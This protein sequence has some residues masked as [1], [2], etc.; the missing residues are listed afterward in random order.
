[1]SNRSRNHISHALLSIVFS[2][3][4]ACT[5]TT[6]TPPT[7]PVNLDPLTATAQNIAERQA[8]I[9]ATS[10]AIELTV[11]AGQFTSTPLPTNASPSET[12]VPSSPTPTLAATQPATALPSATVQPSATTAVTLTSTAQPTVTGTVQAGG[13]PVINTFTADKLM[14]NPGEPLTFT[15]TT[16]NA[17]TVTI[18]H[19]LS[20][21]MFG[22]MGRGDLP[23]NGSAS[24]LTDSN[25]VNTNKFILI[26][27]NNAGVTVS[28]SLDV[29][30]ACKHPWF[31][32]PAPAYCS[33]D[34]SYT[35]SMIEQVFQGGRMVWIA[36]PQGYNS[37]SILY[38]DGTIYTGEDT[39]KN[40]EP[41]S[42]P[43]LVPPAGLYQPVRGFGKVW[44]ELQG[45]RDK[46][47]WALGVETPYNGLFQYEGGTMDAKGWNTYY[48]LEDGHVVHVTGHYGDVAWEYVTP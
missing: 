5:T 48:A 35:R 44:R 24:I 10:T 1:M 47:G 26:V 38:N 18:N 31:F 25:A 2:A 28:Q 15:W 17:S 19:I 37:I 12:P 8:A 32:T 36:Y 30:F 39:W 34:V 20:N 9:A 22:G 13:A 16:T 23:A 4:A 3:L 33:S 43:S 45:A 11:E 40:T 14:L 21:S 41:E 42:D 27:T 6:A 29:T 7:P 46:L